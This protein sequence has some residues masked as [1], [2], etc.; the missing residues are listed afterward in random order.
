MSAKKKTYSDAEKIEYYKQKAAM[1]ASPYR[2]KAKKKK[3]TS[4]KKVAKTSYAKYM[5]PIGGALGTYFGPAGTAI[6]TLAGG[7]AGKLMDSISGHGSYTVN[8]NTVYQNSVPQFTSRVTDGCIRMRHKE[9]IRDVITSPTAG[10]FQNNTLVISASDASTFPYLSQIAVN[11]EEFM[12]EGL[13]FSYVPS[14]G[15]LS[16]TGQL[17]TVIMATQ[18]N[19]LSVPFTNK[20]QAEASTYSV[21]QV[22]SQGALHPIECDAKQTPSQGIFYSKRPGVQSAMANDPRW[23]Q[24][25]VFNLMTQGAPNASETIGE[26]WITYDVILAKPILLQDDS[27]QADHW[28]QTTAGVAASGGPYWPPDAILTTFS[29]GFTQLLPDGVTLAIDPAFNGNIAVSYALHGS[30]GLWVDPL[31]SIGNGAA[32]LN[33]LDSSTTNQYVKSY[34]AADQEIYTTAYFTISGNGGSQ[35]TLIFSGGTFF[36]PVTLDLIIQTLPANFN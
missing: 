33:I 6:G 35:S 10:A 23:S 16:T 21:S 24:L 28:I 22:V 14:S 2:A 1:K 29:D 30:A 7:M 26:L 27:A 19:S 13:V 36:T 4:R 9:F 3:T 32:L 34:L 5:S 15:S 11:F 12:F 31:I 18:Y 17:G 8:A 20:Q 25:G